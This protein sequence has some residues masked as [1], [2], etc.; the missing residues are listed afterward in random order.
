[1]HR[2]VIVT[3]LS[4]AIFAS[5]LAFSSREARADVS[6]DPQIWT[7]VLGNAKLSDSATGPGLWLD[8]H[9]RRS[10]SGTLHI[11]RPGAGY[12]LN[13]WLSI[14]GG[15]AWVPV[16]PDEGDTRH[17]HRPWQQVIV[18]HRF[19]SGLTLQN[20]TR[21]E[22]RFLDSGDDIGFR[23]RDFVRA[24]WS[25]REDGTYGL[26]VWDELFVALN[27]TDWGAESGFDQN[28]LFVGGFAKLAPKLRLELG[29][30]SLYLNR[31]DQD[32]LGHV[33]ATNIFVAL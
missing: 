15:Y 2:G 16:A 6:Q 31:G 13:T 14:W 22:Q 24:D 18:K 5:S 8:M 29:Y 12:R 1:M 23:V 32:T 20:R 28:R 7:A 17:E 21:F 10:D 11:F 25:W 3:A 19:D 4:I 9:L 30:L 33:L 26:V 27:D